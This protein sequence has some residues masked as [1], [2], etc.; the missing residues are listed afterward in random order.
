MREVHEVWYSK[1]DFQDL[2]RAVVKTWPNQVVFTDPEK[3]WNEYWDSQ[4]FEELKDQETEE[5]ESD[6]IWNILNDQTGCSPDRIMSILDYYNKNN[7][8]VDT[9][10][11]WS[12]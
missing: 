9:F 11:N 4:L 12:Y 7:G 1:K 5:M 6:M 10:P 3:I 8:S 2:W